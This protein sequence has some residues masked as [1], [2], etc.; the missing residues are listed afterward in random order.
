[1]KY[2]NPGQANLFMPVVVETL[3][4]FTDISTGKEDPLVNREE[5]SRS[6]LI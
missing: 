4:A 3:G 2:T 5:K 6:Y 1:M